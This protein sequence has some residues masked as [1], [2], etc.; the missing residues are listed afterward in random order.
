MQEAWGGEGGLGEEHLTA[1][2]DPEAPSHLELTVGLHSAGAQGGPEERV[3]I[4]SQGIW[5]QGGIGRECCSV[6]RVASSAG[7]KGVELPPTPGPAALKSIPSVEI[8]TSC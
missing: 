8:F 1:P 3:V 6:G 7:G 5:V 4:S 2:Q